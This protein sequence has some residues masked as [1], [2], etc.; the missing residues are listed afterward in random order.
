MAKKVYNVPNMML[1]VTDIKRFI[2]DGMGFFF[3]SEEEFNRWLEK[4]NQEIRP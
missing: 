3:G 2:D 1:N 4:V